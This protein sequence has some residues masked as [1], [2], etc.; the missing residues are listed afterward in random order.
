[1]ELVDVDEELG[2]IKK[3][4]LRLPV[5]SGPVNM[6][7]VLIEYAYEYLGRQAWRSDVNKSGNTYQSHL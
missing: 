3:E 5:T 1:M 6:L 4:K 7:R 2:K